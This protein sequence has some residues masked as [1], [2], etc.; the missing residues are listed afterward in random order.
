[1][2]QLEQIVTG[3]S[4]EGIIPRETVTV[5]GVVWHGDAVIEL[6]FKDALGRPGNTL[7][8]REDE[9]R[10]SVSERTRPW[11][12]DAPGD[13]FRLVSEAHRIRLAA[14]FD[15]LLAVHTS[16]VQPLPHQILAVYD[17]MLPR[18]PLRFLLADDPG[19]GKTI[20]A[21]LFIRELM[22]RGDLERCLIVA[23][24]NLVEQ[25]QDELEQKFQ[26]PFEIATNDKLEASRTGNW[27][28]ENNL[29]IGRLDK[30]ARDDEVQARLDDTHWDLI[31]VDEAH[32]M[33]ATFFGGEAK[34]T[35]RYRLGQRL[36]QTTRHLLLMTATPHNGKEED[37]QLFMSLLD[38]DRFEGRFRD[39]VH[40]ADCS[41]MMRRMV[42]ERLLKFD[43]KP[44]FP[45]RRAYTAAY[46]LSE[47]ENQLYRD[48]TEYVR[49]EFNRAEQLENDG[50]K[51]TVGFAMTVLQRRLASSPEAIYQS[52]RRRRERLEGKLREARI[53]ASGG[54]ASFLDM[55]RSRELEAIDVDVLEEYDEATAEEAETAEDQVID[56]ATAARSVPELETEIAILN[57]LESAA[58]RVRQS[59]VDKKWEELSRLLQD[60]PEMFDETGSRRKILIFTEHR[61]TLKYLQSRIS[62]L[63]GRP[64][65]IVSIVGGMGRDQ[66]KAAEESF[67]HDPKI[68]V[69]L[70]TDAAGEGINLQRAHLMVNYDLPWNPNR[71]EQ[72]FGRIHR[73]GQTEVCHCWNLVADDTRE[74]DVYRRLLEKLETQRDALGGR[75]SV[76]DVLGKMFAGVSLRNLLIE[77]VRYGELPDV[78]ARLHQAVDNATD[79][80][81]IKELLDADA[82]ATDAMDTRR[83]QELRE[84]MERAE[85]KRLQPYFIQS[86]F[87][88]AFTRLGGRITERESGR[89]Q[90]TRVPASIR[91]RDRQL[92]HGAPVLSEYE[93]ATFEKERIHF[94]GSP[95]AAFICPGHPLL[96]SVI[97]IVLEQNRSLLRQGSMLVDPS[98][99][100][101]SLRVMLLLDH[102]IKDATQLANGENRMVSRETQFVEL[103]AEGRVSDAGAAPYLDYRAATDAERELLEG[104]LDAPWLGE[105]L[106]RTALSYAAREIVPRHIESVRSGREE[107]IDKASQ[108][109]KTR[110]TKEIAYWDHRAQELKAREEAGRTPR[111]NSTMARQ[112]ADDLE[113]RLKRRLERLEQERRLSPAPPVVIGGAVVVPQGLLD[114]LNDVPEEDRD[115]TPDE[116]GRIDKLA[117]KAVLAAERRLGR[118]PRELDHRNPGYDIESS[119]PNEPGR[120][121]FIEVKGKAAGKTTLTVSSTQIRTCCNQRDN[122]ILAV[123]EVDGESASEPR[124]LYGPFDSAPGF[125]E[126]GRNLDL[127][128][129]LEQG[130]AP[131]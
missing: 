128:K 116:R 121:R 22:A 29:T 41:D 110:L 59:G 12:F 61:D 125:L 91:N 45:E 105:D 66:R 73:I 108:A 50:R 19:A 129:I 8:Y 14:L 88:E 57:H 32:K 115:M 130:G 70:A 94:Q 31:V 5:I 11:S 39:G 90:I 63:L 113:A 96:D 109:V 67:R 82:L 84:D 64:E 34:F 77:A 69:L 92:G 126:V 78:R 102:W 4:V 122:W 106:E 62:T 13:R 28:A 111:I 83:V 35:K 80:E 18:Q 101:D 21:G 52:L 56:Q 112:R 118:E 15:P 37:F 60:S 72:R 3:A 6:T 119:D 48:V 55:L 20:M 85:A 81:R 114:K 107:L 23:P 79:R 36:S 44:L 43:G 65:A 1:M 131:S 24:G 25:W 93:R 103:D 127:K 86:F 120:L 89:Y 40:T 17:Q 95:V 30:L 53:I 76:F 87:I 47:A 9:G 104:H 27:F 97:D 71:L 99:P 117:V 54:R 46:T 10:I 42:K 2:S 123:V 68:E 16:L 98:D 7:L 124:Y 26:L 51:G 74:G 58:N 38:G 33:S 75:D 49:Q 100:S